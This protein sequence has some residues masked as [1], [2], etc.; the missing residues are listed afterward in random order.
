MGVSRIGLVAALVLLGAPRLVPAGPPVGVVKVVRGEAV[1][2][3]GDQMLPATPGLGLAE[4]DVLRTG[5][6][7]GL[8]VLLRD[9]TRISLGSRSEVRLDRFAFAPA[10][11]SFALVLRLAR[12]VLSYVSGRIAKL[13][14]DAV[15]VETPVGMVGVR[16]THFA[17]RIEAD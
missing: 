15:R 17:A 7:G 1:V 2:Q 9:D 3:R 12:G 8:G 5:S 4:G 11:G 10:Q 16:G 6:D 14:P 13:A